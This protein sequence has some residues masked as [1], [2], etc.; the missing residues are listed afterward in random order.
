MIF[1]VDA[2]DS[3]P[4]SDAHSVSSSTLVIDPFESAD[5]DLN[6]QAAST[7]PQRTPTKS[8]KPGDPHGAT[9]KTANQTTLEVTTPVAELDNDD[10]PP[11]NRVP[12]KP[13]YT[14]PIYRQVGL[15]FSRSYTLT[16][17]RRL[18]S[19]FAFANE[20]ESA[21][22]ARREPEDLIWSQTRVKGSKLMVPGTV[23]PVELWYIGAV[24]WNGLL[25]NNGVWPSRAKLSVA[26]L[27]PGDLMH[28][29]NLI[30]RFSKT[31]KYCQKKKSRMFILLQRKIWK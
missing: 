25:P 3:P 26:P 9:S 1:K 23:S 24:T 29:R 5:R 19:L 22:A 12:H 10:I 4:P 11:E 27:R 21:Y 30:T 13:E 17:R 31:S 6:W 2:A 18:K 14:K 7:S 16:R 8:S 20:E 15:Q 28:A